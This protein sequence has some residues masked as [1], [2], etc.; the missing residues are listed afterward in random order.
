MLL[1]AMELLLLGVSASGVLSG[2]L[3]GVA[4]ERP[5]PAERLRASGSDVHPATVSAATRFALDPSAG[6]SFM[7]M[8]APAER[9][10]ARRAR[11]GAGSVPA[12]GARRGHGRCCIRQRAVQLQ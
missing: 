7:H 8:G 4:G 6:C 10:D 2:V 9:S 12:D 5:P 11:C 3:A 1:L